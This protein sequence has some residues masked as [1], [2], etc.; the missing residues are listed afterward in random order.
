MLNLKRG[1]SKSADTK[2]AVNSVVSSISQSDIKFVIFFASSKYDFTLV[3]K[4]MKEAFKSA[5][6][7]GCTTAGEIGSQGFTE[8]TLV[9]MSIAA[10]DFTPATAVIKDIKKRAMLGKN[11]VINA[12]N[13]T[14]MDIN[15]VAV[16]KK[17]FGILLIDGMQAAEEKVMSV[18]SLIFKEFPILG[19]SAGDD[20]K[21]KETFVSANG[22]VYSNA[23]VVTFIKTGKKFYPYKEN[24]YAPT[25]KE[26]KVTKVDLESRT[27]FEFNNLPAIQEYAAALNVP[28]DKLQSCFMSSPLGRQFSDSIWITSPYR[29]EGDGIQFYAQLMQ[30][31]VVR[32]LKAIDPV[33]EA[34]KT[35]EKIKENVPNVKGIIAF[36]CILRYLQFKSQNVCSPVYNELSKLGE[37]I[38]F[39]TYGEQYYKH[40]VN[41]TLTLIALGE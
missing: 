30:N 3:S 16:N 11:E 13:K 5:E 19:G 29:I 33:E 37:V 31:S 21:F 32:V 22:E 6:V 15:D 4:S 18:F 8:G 14:G 26:L 39:S 28:K 34:R 36:N 2:E 25:E 20:L 40:H 12:F 7:I 35:V 9:A 27:V 23:A 10:D 17:G 38:G 1:F 41:Q 24:I